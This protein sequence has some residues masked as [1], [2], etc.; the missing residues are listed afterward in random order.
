MIQLIFGFFAT[1]G[2][3]AADWGAVSRDASDIRLGGWVGVAFGS[4]LVATLAL[5]T[6]AGRWDGS[7]RLRVGRAG[8]APTPSASA[9]P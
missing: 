8:R 9:R 6:V 4:W 5:M 1:A 7:P 2:L 3:A